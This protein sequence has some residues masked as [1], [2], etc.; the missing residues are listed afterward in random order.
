MVI[1]TPGNPF[2][3]SPT[4]PLSRLVQF[5]IIAIQ[6][7]QSVE[8]D[9]MLS[10]ACAYLGMLQK[11]INMA[12]INTSKFNW[13]NRTYNHLVSWDRRILHFYSVLFFG[14]L[15][16]W[17]ALIAFQID[18]WKMRLQRK[19]KVKWNSQKAQLSIWVSSSPDM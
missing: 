15:S 11:K 12:A 10:R 17:L 2:L 13:K 8:W 19:N 14:N 5:H 6:A 1:L 4:S 7:G 18:L 9:R 3:L 16:N